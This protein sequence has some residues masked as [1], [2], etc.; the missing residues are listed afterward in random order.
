MPIIQ[1][2]RKCLF[3]HRVDTAVRADSV[4]TFFRNRCIHNI[5]PCTI[6]ILIMHR[7]SVGYRYFAAV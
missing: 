1:R 4:C 5:L 6:L 3:L 2:N 7:D